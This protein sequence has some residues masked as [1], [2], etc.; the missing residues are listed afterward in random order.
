MFPG[1]L[2]INLDSSRVECLDG[3]KR[4]TASFRMMQYLDHTSCA[5]AFAMWASAGSLMR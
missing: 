4:R 2:T 1:S 5:P 3:V